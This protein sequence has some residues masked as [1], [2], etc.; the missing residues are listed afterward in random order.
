[1]PLTKNIIFDWD[2]I[3]YFK[4]DEFTCNCGCGLNNISQEL[5]FNLDEA[6]DIAQIP[7]KINSAS[8]CKKHNQSKEVGGVKNSSHCKGLAVDISCSN[9][10]FRFIM[11]SALLNVGFKRVLIYSTF[12]HVDIDTDKP[13]PILKLMK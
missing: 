11:V 7:F 13:H 6:R 3:N 1:M 8:R 9:D 5:V 12:I 4:K 10:E 2:D